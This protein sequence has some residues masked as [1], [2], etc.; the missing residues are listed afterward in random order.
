[1]GGDGNDSQRHKE[2][3]VAPQARDACHMGREN[4]TERNKARV[5][6]LDQ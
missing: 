1:V 5:Q 3:N 2:L 4:E 6:C